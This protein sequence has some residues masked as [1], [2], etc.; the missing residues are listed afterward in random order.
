MIDIFKKIIM[1]IVF[2]VDISLFTVTFILLVIRTWTNKNIP[3][4]D[5]IV[6][7]FGLS[8]IFLVIIVVFSII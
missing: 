2:I 8:F 5:Y 1:F 6:Y 7:I 3:E 4:N